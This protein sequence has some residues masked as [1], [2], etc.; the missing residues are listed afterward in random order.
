MIT[1][2]IS[3][4]GNKLFFF[5]IIFHLGHVHEALEDS[6]SYKSIIG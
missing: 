1:N 5:I 6:K 3:D 2:D 4:K